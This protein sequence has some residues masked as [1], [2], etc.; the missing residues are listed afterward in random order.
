MFYNFHI[1]NFTLLFTQM[2]IL[3][4]NRELAVIFKFSS[5]MRHLK[6]LR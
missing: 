6:T 4:K 2:E 5:E 1:E 3:V